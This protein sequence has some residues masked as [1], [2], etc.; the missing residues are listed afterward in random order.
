[1]PSLKPVDLRNEPDT[2]TLAE[3]IEMTFLRDSDFLTRVVSS[4][5]HPGIEV[6]LHYHETHDEVF[7]VIQGRVRYTIGVPGAKFRAISFLKATTRWYTPD[8]GEIFIPKGTA[9]SVYVPPGQVSIVEENA[10]PMD[11]GKEVFFRNL[12]HIGLM[13]SAPAVMQAFYY[14]DCYPVLPGGIRILEKASDGLESAVGAEE[15][16]EEPVSF[17]EDRDLPEGLQLRLDAY[18]AAWSKCL[19]QIQKIAESLRLPVVSKVVESVKNAHT[20][21]LPGLPYEE[22][23]MVCI[24]DPSGQSDTLREITERL[25]G[26]SN[27]DDLFEDDGPLTLITHL[28]PSASLNLTAAMRE[29]I[30]GRLTCYPAPT[31]RK[32]SSSANYS[33]EYLHAWYQA[34]KDTQSQPSHLVVF[35]HDLEQFDSTVLQDIFHI[36][37]RH[38]PRLPLVFLATL[39]SPPSTHFIQNT[40]PRETL[41]RLRLTHA[42]LPHGLPALEQIIVKT[43]FDVDFRPDVLI[44]PAVLDFL[45]DHFRRYNSGI[46]TVQSIIQLA[47]MKHFL[48]PLA[49][50]VSDAF[51]PDSSDFSATKHLLVQPSS[52]AFLESLLVR[53]HA[54]ADSAPNAEDSWQHETIDTLLE[55]LDRERTSFENHVDLL[56]TWVNILVIVRDFLV[57]EGSSNVTGKQQ[58]CIPE[59][60]SLVLKGD[61][62]TEIQYFCKSIQ[63]LTTEQVHNLL[64]LLDAFLVALPT[65]DRD[66]ILDARHQCASLISR[67]TD[68]DAAEEATQ[69][70]ES[71]SRWLRQQWSQYLVPPE[72]SSKLWDIWYTGYS[73]FPSEVLNPATRPSLLSGLLQPWSYLQ[74][75]ESSAADY[76]LWQLPDTSIL[77]RRYLD[78]GKMLNVYDWFESFV[79]VL[80]TQRNELGK[81]K[82]RTQAAKGGSPRKKAR[83][84]PKKKGKEVAVVNDDGLEEEYDEEKWKMEVQARFIRALQELDYLGFIKHTQRKQDHVLRTVFDVANFA[85]AVHRDALAVKFT[86]LDEKAVKRKID[87]RVLPL[88]I[89]SYIFNQF[90][91]TNIGNAHVLKPFNENFGIS[92][93]ARW[94]LALSI[95]YVGYCLLEI[96]ANILQRHIGANRFFFLSLSFWGIV[97]LSFTYAKGYTSLLVLRVLLG[98]GEAGYYAGMIY[99]LSFCLCMTGTL[100]GAIGGLLAFGLARAHTHVLT[101]WQ[102]LFLIEAIP[103]LIMAVAILLFL[104][105]FPFSASFLSPR[106]KAIAQARLNK[107]HRPQSHGGMSGWQGFKAIITDINAWLFM[108]IYASF[109]VGVATVSY[110]LPTLIRDLGFSDINAQGLTV[111]PYV[112]GWFM[113]FFQAWH[114]DRTKDRGYHIMLSCAISFTGYVIL[115]NLAQTNVGA[116]YFALFLVVGGNYSL[117]PLVMSWAANAFSPTSKRGVGTAFIVSI[118]N[119]VSVA[120]PQ[121][122]FDAEDRFRKGHAISAGMLALSFLAALTLRTRLSWLNKKHADYMASLTSDDKEAQELE[123]FNGTEEIWDT[124]PR[125]Q[126]KL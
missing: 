13:G 22:L 73:P 43:F 101:G 7:R 115:A 57:Q 84:P 27:T 90:D 42:T 58:K 83:N 96:P 17:F 1:M 25:S 52:F 122:Y 14:G 105:S 85:D 102:F 10:L 80:E 104:P 117:F 86:E 98:I 32:A 62:D 125:Y 126:Y 112:V 55:A 103:T 3:G 81:L 38:V 76:T 8:D 92:T 24:S 69:I 48:D 2:V 30:G 41:R 97:S 110:F 99:Y 116:S 61:V 89:C 94:T 75:D 100:P 35:L 6:P 44:G 29:M 82:K 54:P 123:G 20:D 34:L 74:P 107:D 65:E 15:E 47:Y 113:V 68:D 16:E 124:D 106:E 70:Q 9:H 46:D 60:L 56:R 51:Y 120:S 121:V 91:R 5:D 53:V 67:F 33:F 21:T 4:P 71:T 77:F 114:S 87:N 49:V 19:T 31:R 111:A 66:D 36:C 45:Y 23:P 26:N 95:F 119:C 59:I 72:E 79:L 11:D 78:S 64:K 88:V 109:N 39:T 18:Q 93:N 12:C 108:L 50:L 40:Y 28:H 37:S 63:K 118:S